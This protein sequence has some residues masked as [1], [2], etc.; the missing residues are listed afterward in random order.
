MTKKTIL[1]EDLEKQTF[2]GMFTLSPGKKVR[3]ELVLAGKQSSLYLWDD[4]FIGYER[5]EKHRGYV[6][7][8]KGVS[9]NLKKVSLIDCLDLGSGSAN[10]SFPE[11]DTIHNAHFLPFY[12]VFGD[13]HVSPDE[14]TII[15]TS[16]VIEDEA[17]FFCDSNAFGVVQTP[18]QSLVNQ[19][20][21]EA[22]ENPIIAYYRGNSEIFTAHPDTA[23]DTISGWRRVRHRGGHT[24]A[25]IEGEVS[26]N[27]K[28]ATAVAFEDAINE[29]FKVLGFL[30]LLA[31]RPQNLMDFEI[32]KESGHEV[33]HVLQVYGVSFPSMRDEKMTE[34]RI[35]PT[36]F[37]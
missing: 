23:L 14:K 20:V 12:A 32:Y 1:M 27:L 33:P 6:K 19:V 25:R 26:V 28:F 30:E 11:K 16:I 21:T 10:R 4:N 22:G 18:S 8:I 24:G 29:S 36:M 2:A 5:D 35:F 17:T 9:N 31:G 3:G 34:N 37:L 7:F 13:D 15:E